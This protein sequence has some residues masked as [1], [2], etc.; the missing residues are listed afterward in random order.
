MRK[1]RLMS[2]VLLASVLCLSGCAKDKKAAGPKPVAIDKSEY[3][4]PVTDRFGGDPA[5]LV[6]GDTVY[7]YTGHDTSKNDTYVIPEY[8]CYSSKDMKSWNYE[9]VVMSMKDVAWGDNNSAWAGQVAKYND[10]YYMY[11]CSWDKTSQGKQSIGVAVSDSPTGPFVDIGEPLVKGTATTNQ[12]SDW[13]DIDPT[14]WIED[15]HR[16]LM[17]GNGKV[18][19][20]ELN[21]DMVSVKDVNEDGEIRFGAD[22]IEKVAPGSY[23][24]APWIYRRSDE[25]GKYYGDYYFFYASSWREE[26]SYATTNDLWKGRLEYQDVIME[27]TATSNTNHMAVVDFGGKTYFIYHNGALDNGSGYRR[28]ICIAEIQFESDGAIKPMEESAAGIW[29]TT[30]SITTDKGAVAH[31]KFR[32]S[33][34]DNAYPYMNVEVGIGLGTDL[35]AKWVICN[36]KTE[37]ADEYMVSIQSENK[38]GLFL[39]VSDGMI[40]LS[41]N[42]KGDLKSAM[43]FKTYETSDGIL[44]ESIM[45][46]GKFITVDD[47]GKLVLGE[48]T[49]F[50]IQ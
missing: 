34:A 35:D 40:G 36:G 15:D 17:W 24:E 22:I 2:A 26:M 12:S 11:F 14:V 18:Y 43:T 33:A 45:E 4:N 13:N 20:C 5:V 16:Y 23:T 39:T 32:N 9:G 7:L 48:G 6:D 25:S 21:E 42:D 27:H 3:T 31:K 29:G 1:M 28:S 47:E 46:E 49:A 30:V 41:Q 10:K 50:Q 19:I 8:L 38:P 37:G 44:F